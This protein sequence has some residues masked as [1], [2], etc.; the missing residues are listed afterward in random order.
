MPNG[1]RIFGGSSGR[2]GVVIG[3][4]DGEQGLVMVVEGSGMGC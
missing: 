4:R 2:A 1:W 3:V